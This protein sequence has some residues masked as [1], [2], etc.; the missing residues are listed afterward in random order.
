MALLRREEWVVVALLPYYAATRERARGAK[1]L[2][3]T[4]MKHTS[5]ASKR[6]HHGSDDNQRSW[7]ANIAA[8]RPVAGQQGNSVSFRQSSNA[9]DAVAENRFT[10]GKAGH[11]TWDFD[12]TQGTARPTVSRVERQDKREDGKWVLGFTPKVEQ[13]CYPT[14][15]KPSEIT[16]VSHCDRNVKR[17]EVETRDRDTGEKGRRVVTLVTNEIHLLCYGQHFVFSMTN[18]SK[19]TFR[20][21]RTVTAALPKGKSLPLN[22]AKSELCRML[23]V[24]VGMAKYAELVALPPKRPATSKPENAGNMGAPSTVAGS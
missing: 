13:P 5:N 4:S 6:E 11:T 18:R 22:F 14:A 20:D 3:E 16:A 17:F 7:Q 2:R 12:A 10:Y 15:Q 24:T 9:F 8:L 19:R 1:P 23:G 21:S